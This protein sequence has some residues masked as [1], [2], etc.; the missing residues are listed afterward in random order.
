MS[1]SRTR[2]LFPVFLLSLAAGLAGGRGHAQEAAAPAIPEP[3]AAPLPG[4]PL[5]EI[6]TFLEE[7]RRGLRT[8]ELLVDQYTFNEKRMERRYDAAG[9]VKEVTL[10]LYEVYPSPNPGRTYR[11]LVER[12]GRPLPTKEIEEQE[13]KQLA[14]MERDAADP[15]AAARRREKKQAEFRR[16]EQ[17]VVDELFQIYEITITGRETLEGR[18]AIVVAF[19]PR[20]EVRP[21]TRTGK[22]LQK[23][24]G[25]A[26]ID[27]QDR[28]LAR[29]EAKLLENFSYGLGVLARLYK[30]ASAYFQRRKVN[31]EVW[32]PAEARFTGSARILLVK[33]LRVDSLSEYSEYKKF[34]V[35]TVEEVEAEKSPP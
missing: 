4:A 13:R 28:Q 9:K 6:R 35:A 20:L 31:G 10:E 12:N 17:Q 24:E 21:S 2:G 15:A 8:D 3:A 1:R 32:L 25:K 16:R 7:V 29:A 11:K 5:P 18:P 19:R 27:E 26:W 23:F 14:R 34:S 33:G 30:G 22:I